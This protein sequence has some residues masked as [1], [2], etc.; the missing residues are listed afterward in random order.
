MAYTTIDDP[1]VYFHTRLYTSNND[2]LVVTNNA[3]SGDFQ[4]DWIWIKDRGASTDHIL[5]D[6]SRGITKRLESN[7]SDAE[8]ANSQDVKSVQSNGFTLGNNAGVNAG[9]SAHVAWQWKAN[10]G[11]TTTN[12]ASS[13]GVGSIDSVYQANTTAGFSIVTY[14]GTGSAGTIAHGLGAVPNFMLIK[15][16]SDGSS[17]NWSVYH[18]KSFVSAS[19]PNILYLN[20]TA[21]T[22]DDTNVFHTTTTFNSTVFSV[23]NYNGSNGSSDNIVAYCFVEKKGY[24]KF[25]SYTGN[26]NADGPFVYTGF[27]PRW[28]LFKNT[29]A[30]EEWV[31]QDT[32]RNPNNPVIINIRVDS[33]SAE[34]SASSLDIDF[35]SNGFKNRSDQAQLNSDGVSYVY[36]AF[37]ESPFVSSEGVPTTAR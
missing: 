13:T 23:G 9:T 21:A 1:S 17:A 11:T 30:A 3:N 15:N 24:S 26:G 31:L 33:N 8:G 28:I 10:G 19:D 18:H 36:M 6:T 2:E 22:A 5:S 20:T 27:K 35:L 29:G 32:T 12:D 14:T 7:T 16:R 37:A 34:A 4:P 25:G